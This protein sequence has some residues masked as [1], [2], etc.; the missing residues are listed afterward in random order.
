MPNT[1]TEPEKVVRRRVRLRNASFEDYPRIARLQSRYFVK[2]ESLEEWKHLWLGNSLYRELE[3]HW[4]P[5]WV[6]EDQ[7][8][9]IVGSIGNIPLLYEFDGNRVIAATGRG[10]VVEPEHRSSTLPLLDRVINQP[11]ID[12]YLNNTVTEVSLDLVDFF[13][14][15]RVPAGK[16]DEMALWITHY[17]E[18]LEIFLHKKR[19]RL[20]APLSYPISSAAYLYDKLRMKSLRE[21]SSQVESC[22]G[23]DQ[24]FDDFWFDLRKNSPDRLLAVRSREVLQWH[25][26]HALLNNQLW[27]AAV[28]SGRSLAAYAIFLRSDD[29]DLGLKRVQLV[30]YQSLDGSSDPLMPILCWAL[31]RCRKE[32]IHILYN[33]GRWLEQGEFFDIFAP[34]RRKL[35][36]WVYFYRV[37]N[38][39]LADG[40]RN[41]DTWSPTVFD[42][43]ATLTSRRVVETGP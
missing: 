15:Q 17:R 20:A 30:D 38:P 2:V 24:R 13:E 25:F 8:R 7:N 39:A 11:G 12:L 9:E 22:P 19:I 43:D 1:M 18:A 36:N 23:F 14:C 21:G 27:I 34:H 41:R 32:R 16:W 26:H 37:P 31:R 35:P 3:R 6:I 28:S 33:I 42:G 4:T 5:G 40:L 29:A 10:L